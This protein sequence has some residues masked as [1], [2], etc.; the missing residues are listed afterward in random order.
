VR[1]FALVVFAV[2]LLSIEGVLCRFFHVEVLRPDF[3]LVLVI[4]LATRKEQESVIVV[5]F[6][7]LIAESFAG[8][9]MGMLV[10]N[11]IPIWVLT[12]W[13]RKYLMVEQGLTRVGLV[14]SSSLLAYAVLAV[15]VLAAPYNPGSG[16]VTTLMIWIVPLASI[17]AFFAIPIWNLAQRILGKERPE[18]RMAEWVSH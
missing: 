3:V 7:G 11:Y 2:I 15:F 6:L 5:F 12:K 10:I 17:N 9:P 1:S 8:L 4:M 14:F 13:L 18:A 16:L